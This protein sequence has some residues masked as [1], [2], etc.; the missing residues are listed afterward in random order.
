MIL[1]TP[2][3]KAL[4]SSD[5]SVLTRATRLNNPEDGILHSHRRDNLKSYEKIRVQGLTLP[6]SLASTLYIYI[7]IYIYI[8]YC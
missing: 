7:Y 6:V 1:I 4:R 3:M 5:T 2:M 8:Y